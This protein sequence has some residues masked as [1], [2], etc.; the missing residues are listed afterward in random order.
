MNRYHTPQAYIIESPPSSLRCILILS[1]LLTTRSETGRLGTEDVVQKAL[2]DLFQGGLG[3]GDAFRGGGAHGTGEALEVNGRVVGD[4]TQRGRSVEIRSVS[5]DGA[6]LRAHGCGLRDD[7]VSFS[8]ILHLDKSNTH[9]F[10][11]LDDLGARGVEVDVRKERNADIEGLGLDGRLGKVGEVNGG[12][13]IDC[14]EGAASVEVAGRLSGG[15]GGTLGGRTLF[16]GLDRGT[17]A[18]GLQGIG[19]Q[20]LGKL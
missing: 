17:E 8:K 10:D 1:L 20:A 6:D 15:D 14:L 9:G 5:R 11:L 19:G 18:T 2:P 12:A 4:I 7:H 16:A 3:L 13:V